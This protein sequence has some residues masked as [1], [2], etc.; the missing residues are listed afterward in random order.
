MSDPSP[1]PKTLLSWH[2]RPTTPTE[3]C[4]TQHVPVVPIPTP[5]NQLIVA[6]SHSSAHHHIPVPPSHSAPVSLV[7]LPHLALSHG[8]TCP[9]MVAF[10]GCP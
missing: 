10:G 8:D 1:S 4:Q 9:A 6:S 3:H 7:P 2:P 5:P